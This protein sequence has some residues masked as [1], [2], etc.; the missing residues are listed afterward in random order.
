[1]N[2]VLASFLAASV[3][4]VTPSPAPGGRVEGAVRN[5]DGTGM[6]GIKI[7]MMRQFKDAT[8]WRWQESVALTRDDGSFVFEHV[9][10]GRAR[11]TMEGSSV[12]PY[13]SGQEKR[14]DIREGKTS[15]VEFALR[16]ILVS[17]RVTRSGAPAAGLRVTVKPYDTRFKI[18]DPGVPAPSSDPQWMTGVTRE[19]GRYALLVDVPGGGTVQLDALDGRTGFPTQRVTIPDVDA[20][21]LD[22]NLAGV[23]V[24][25]TVVDKDT[26]VPIA[27][28]VSASHGRAFMRTDADGRFRFELEPGEYTFQANALGKGYSR[29][30]T[31]VTVGSAGTPEVRLALS[32]RRISGKVIDPAGR[33]VA[34]VPVMARGRYSSYAVTLADGAF[35]IGGL[36]EQPYTLTAFSDAGFFAAQSDVAGGAE[37]VGLTLRPG[38]RV[39]LQVTGP[40]GSPLEGVRA[41]VVKVDGRPFPAWRGAKQTD[42]LGRL[43]LSTPTG[44]VEIDVRSGSRLQGL[45]TVG[46]TSGGIVDATIALKEASPANTP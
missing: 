18:P 33:G 17:G 15:T 38:G 24:S 45:T 5:R 9:P 8:R 27:A 31:S 32:G 42:A 3:G 10:P 30:E 39:R 35:Q 46:V 19:D 29:L 44:S 21:T 2:C 43:E 6:P 26:G 23:P 28:L 36:D 7:K 16:K 34:G 4:I 11:I 20:H 14:V 40:E 41:A 22:V 13:R 12:D 25:G 37:G 1:M